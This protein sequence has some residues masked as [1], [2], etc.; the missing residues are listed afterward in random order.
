MHNKPK[1]IYN[2]PRIKKKTLLRTNII[3]TI[4]KK[5]KTSFFLFNTLEFRY[6]QDKLRKQEKNTTKNK[7]IIKIEEIKFL[8]FNAHEFKNIQNKPR[9]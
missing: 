3:I 8:L 7:H 1:N 6:I 9:E 4:G 2:K 5:K